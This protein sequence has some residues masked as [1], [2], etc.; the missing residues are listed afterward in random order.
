MGHMNL[1]NKLDWLDE[2]K[3]VLQMS[4]T[5]Q[6]FLPFCPPHCPTPYGT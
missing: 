1:V 5:L 3:E 4:G 6:L 2:E